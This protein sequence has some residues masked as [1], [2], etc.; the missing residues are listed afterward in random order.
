MLGLSEATYID[1][2]LARFNMQN[3]K[4]GLLS[5]RH[6]I[7]LTKE[8]YPKTPQEQ[9]RMKTVPYASVVGSLMYAMLCT[10]PDICFA[11]GMAS[12]YQSNPGLEH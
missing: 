7:P 9:E 5:I 11:V 6:G 8:Q 12:R 10:W 3:S 1:T 2:I 4:K